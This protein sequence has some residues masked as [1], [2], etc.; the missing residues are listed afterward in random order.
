MYEEEKTELAKKAGGICAKLTDNWTL[1]GNFEGNRVIIKSGQKQLHLQFPWNDTNRLMISG[2]WPNGLYNFL[3]YNKLKT[4]I[5]VTKDKAPERIA[6]DI[7]KRLLPNYEKMLQEAIKGKEVNDA[8]L[9]RKDKA[10]KRIIEAIGGDA[11]I[12]EHNQQVHSWKP[13]DCTVEYHGHYSSDEETEVQLRIRL[14]L[15]KV[16]EI[17]RDL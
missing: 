7:E 13:Y 12:M 6:R 3:P 17:L 16:I 2:S 4:E 5:T 10:L 14:P 8:Y 15:E 1:D 11:H 9:D